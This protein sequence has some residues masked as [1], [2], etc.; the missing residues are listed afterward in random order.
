MRATFRVQIHGEETPPDFD[1][2]SI[3]QDD[4]M[5]FFVGDH[6]FGRVDHVPAMFYIETRF[7]HIYYFPFVPRESYLFI[8]QKP[9]YGERKGIRIPICWK[10]VLIAWTRACFGGLCALMIIGGT[11]QLF[12]SPQVGQDSPIVKAVVC[13]T[14]AAFFAT[15]FGISHMG[16]R[17]TPNRARELAPIL[18]LSPDEAES[19]ANGV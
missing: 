7:L 13:W 12:Q 3:S 14:V 18:G 15:V 11:L 5:V 1:P 9:I 6:Y 17:A 2:S 10:S 8:D 19:R 16:T 4:P